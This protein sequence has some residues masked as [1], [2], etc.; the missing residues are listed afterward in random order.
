MTSLLS[1]PDYRS[2]NLIGRCGCDPDICRL[3]QQ[4][5]SYSG[6]IYPTRGLGKKQS[7]LSVAQ[8]I[9]SYIKKKEILI[10]TKME[11]M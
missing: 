10:L 7:M 4:L 2:M 11:D 6:E 1:W 8:N 9:L 5:T 3:K